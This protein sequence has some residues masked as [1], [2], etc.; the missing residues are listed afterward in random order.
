M[1]DG[2]AAEDLALRHLQAQGLKAVARNWRCN[3]GELDLVM[4]HGQTLVIAEVRK[5]SSS[6]FGGAAASVDARKRGRIL[7]TAQ[8]FLLEHP[9]YAEAPL[10][11][12][13]LTLDG[14]DRIEWLQAA[15][16]S[17]V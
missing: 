11:F 13:V 6:A 4:R 2:A 7:R 8:L 3:S 10:R 14:A 1:S 5:R 15:F 17:D 9:Q 16:D 12:D